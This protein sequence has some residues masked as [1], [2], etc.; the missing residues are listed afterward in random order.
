MIIRIVRL[1]FD[2][3]KTEDF[4]KIFNEY[5]INIRDFHGC[6]HLELHRDADQRNIFATNS[7]WEGPE[8]LESYLKSE[9]FKEIW[10][11]T[12]ILFSG[13]PVAFS[14]ERVMIVEPDEPAVI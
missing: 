1:T 12:K 13:K 8:D 4:L 11:K 10:S 7:Y 3:A 9:L 6:T 5:K 2:P 14:H